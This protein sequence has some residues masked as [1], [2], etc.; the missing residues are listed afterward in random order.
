MK[1]VLALTYN[2]SF[3]NWDIDCINNVAITDSKISK[4]IVL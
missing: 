3:K 4:N 2:I 1:L